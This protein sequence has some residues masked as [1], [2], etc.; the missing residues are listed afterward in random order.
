VHHNTLH[1][2]QHLPFDSAIAEAEA[3][4][5][6]HGYWPVERM[7]KE[8]RRGR[9]TDDDLAAVLAD[10]PNLAAGEVVGTI[11]G[12]T[13]TDTDVRKLHLVHGVNPTDP[14]TLRFL[15]FERGA[16]YRLMDD[17]PEES[18]AAG[19]AKARAELSERID[20]VGRDLTL[21]DWLG[22]VLGLDITSAV[23]SVARQELANLRVPSRTATGLL[24]RLGIP[25]ARHS[26]YLAVVDRR[27]AAAN[28]SEPDVARRVWLAVEA[29]LVDTLA[30]RHLNLRGRLD[31][32]EAG[33][34]AAPESLAVRALWNSCVAAFGYY[35]PFS[36]TDPH[37]LAAR[38]PDGYLDRI[39]D[40]LR[41]PDSDATA[42][43]PLDPDE[44]A[45]VEQVARRA[46]EELSVHLVEP[47]RS[48][49]KGLREAAGAAWFALNELGEEG[50]T[51]TGFDALD[52]LAVLQPDSEAAEVARRLRPKHPTEIVRA[53]AEGALEAELSRFGADTTHADVLLGL[54]GQDVTAL[55]NRYM[56]RLCAAFLDAGQAAWRMPDRTLGFYGA[57]RSSVPHDPTL[58]IAGVEGWPTGVADLPEDPAEA[59]L[60]QLQRLGIESKHR[61]AY[62]ARALARLPG[63]AAMMHWRGTNPGYAPQKVR[64]AD[65]LQ[66]LA[67][68]LTVETVILADGFRRALGI[69]EPHV[70][71]ISNRLRADPFEH[72]VRNALH[73]GALPAVLAR[74]AHDLERKGDRSQW[75]I[76][77]HHAWS[78]TRHPET[79]TRREVSD[80]PWR[81]FRLAQLAGWSADEVRRLSPSPRDRIIAVLDSWPEREHRSVWLAAFERHYR[82]E[83]LGA[84][85]ANRGKGRWQV[86]DARPKAQVVFCIDERE[87]SMHRAVDELD[88]Q[89][90]TFGAGGFFNMAMNFSAL[91]DHDITPL[92]PAGVI[93]T[94]RVKEVP[95]DDPASI[96]AAKTRDNRRR[97]REAA[98][99][100]YWELKRNA[101]S[102]VFVAQLVGLV[103]SIPLTARVLAPRA[104][105]ELTDRI[106]KAILPAP[107]TQLTVDA[108]RFPGL[109]F[110]PTEQADRIEIQ[111]RN[112]GLTTNFA[113]LVVFMGHGSSSLNNPHESAHDCGAC[114]GKHGA[115]NAR[116]FAALAN[117]PSVRQ[118]L[119]SRGIEIPDDTRFVGGIHNT[120]NDHNTFFDVQDIPD[121][122]RMEW[123]ALRRHLDEAR[124]RSARERCR[125]FASAPKTASLA[126]SVRHVEERTRDLS[127]VRPEWGHC[128]NAVAVIGR[129]ALTQGLFL[130]RRT[131]V[132]SYDARIDPEG[133]IVQRILLALGPV[134]AGINL[135]YY[136]S[137]VDNQKFGCDTKVPH[138]VTGL[139]GVME[140]AA[141]DLRTGLPKQMIELHE[142]MR[143]LLIVEA[144]TDVLGKIYTT[145]PVIAE[146][147]DNEWV[148]LVALSPTDGSF[149]LFVPGRGFVAWDGEASQ[150]PVERSSF[151]YYHGRLDFLPPVRIEPERAQ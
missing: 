8:H 7:R 134:G 68:R 149:Q 71:A 141:S 2:F 79:T 80:K 14:G 112:I 81:L 115:P 93:P 110:T 36:A 37:T 38:D 148:H 124:A 41:D 126:R 104:W 116:A 72:Y 125:R 130:D 146:L 18:A 24:E 83:I 28:D 32:L 23:T 65:L 44:R 111:L 15:V 42:H 51:R 136:F 143:L 31:A 87:E 88:P 9:I 5:G 89:Y 62:L 129:R 60:L 48:G 131:F 90:E 19:V 86:R 40:A 25:A 70:A 16:R 45:A 1:G 100:T 33:L 121:T 133:A 101:V 58:S 66:Y 82:E 12:R 103:Q 26:G 27:L 49:D 135:E 144:S 21:A 63:W 11:G 22:E 55:V 120:A 69:D 35:D 47:R 61:H 57:W 137:T 53:T 30:R 20:Q 98:Q 139:I 123:E 114:G 67:V 74:A 59:L 109:G 78:W 97:W 113:R 142:P 3:L 147:L 145:Q 92:C 39:G 127:Q 64:P 122:H 54:T 17:V 29:R 138:N 99:N 96:A 10:R 151:D 95:R 52:A 150:L 102:G 132:I 4:Y 117:A 73:R 43:I 118:E 84:L 140:G 77:A 106:D 119:A 128:T 108:E 13:V 107:A 34:T 50:Y 75:S 46:W 85:A 94:N 76:L 91:D 56:I 6:A 105:G